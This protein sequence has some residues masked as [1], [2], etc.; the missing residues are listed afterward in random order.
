VG[1]P[2]IEPFLQN[3][4]EIK[5]KLIKLTLPKRPNIP[6]Y[7]VSKYVCVIQGV[8]KKKKKQRDVVYLLLTYNSALVYES[9]CEGRGGVT[10]SQPMSTA[11][12]IT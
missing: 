11:V 10:G 8:T 7:S 3:N 1:A 2:S 12:H 5:Y 4:L 6:K 9:K